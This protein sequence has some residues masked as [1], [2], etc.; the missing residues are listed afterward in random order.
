VPDGAASSLLHLDLRA[1]NLLVRRGG[2]RAVIDWSNSMVGDPAL[3]L[4][5]TAE[6]ARLAENGLDYA[7]FVRGYTTVRP[8]PV[9]SAACWELYRLDAAAMLAVVFNSEAPDPVRGPETLRWLMRRA[10][11]GFAAGGSAG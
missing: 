3:E 7:D 2:I 1:A 9:R 10:R 4:A 6:Y 11:D 8:H 5:R